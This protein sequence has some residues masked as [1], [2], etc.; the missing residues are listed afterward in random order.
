MTKF[1]QSQGI[2]TSREI[3]V[4]PCPHTEVRAFEDTRRH[5]SRSLDKKLSL[6]LR[7]PDSLMLEFL[8]QKNVR[9]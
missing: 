1:S 4:C 8:A 7:L 5:E 9:K 2:E 6:Q 3:T